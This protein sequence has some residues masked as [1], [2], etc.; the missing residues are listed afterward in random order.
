MPAAAAAMATAAAAGGPYSTEPPHRGSADGGTSAD[1]REERCQGLGQPP[2]GE[3][4]ST[5]MMDF[6]YCNGEWS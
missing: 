4:G 3:N 1:T 6:A 2:C 5:S